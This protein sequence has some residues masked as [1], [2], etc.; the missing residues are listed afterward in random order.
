MARIRSAGAAPRLSRHAFARP[1]RSWTART[2]AGWCPKR[3]APYSAWTGSRPSG[4][5]DP[6]TDIL[7]FSSG[8][9]APPIVVGRPWISHGIRDEILPIDRCGRRLSRGRADSGHDMDHR[10]F[11]GGAHRAARARGCCRRPVHGNGIEPVHPACPTSFRP[12]RAAPG[13]VGVVTPGPGRLGG[14]DRAARPEAPR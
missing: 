5:G 3:K 13:S 6:L 9:A 14:G 10:A 4:T 7:A 2:R 1:P 8:S 12:G 11:V